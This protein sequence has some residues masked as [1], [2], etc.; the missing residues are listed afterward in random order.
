[1]EQAKVTMT[2]FEALAEIA[3]INQKLETQLRYSCRR[4]YR[5]SRRQASRQL[6]TARFRTEENSKELASAFQSRL[7]LLKRREM[8]KAA[9]VQSNAT[10]FITLA[11]EQYR[12]LRAI[13]MRKMLPQHKSLITLARNGYSSAAARYWN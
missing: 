8:L 12:A 10:T 9:L 11:G 5:R 6:P 7:D 1:M 2:V 3:R 4:S 13:E